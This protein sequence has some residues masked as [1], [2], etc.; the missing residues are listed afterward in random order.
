M[1]DP[2]LRRVT[3]TMHKEHD[4]EGTWLRNSIELDDVAIL[5][6]T[7]VTFVLKT[8][9]FDEVTHRACVNVLSHQVKRPDD[10]TN[11]T[12]E[13]LLSCICHRMSDI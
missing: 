9:F 8:C 13:G 3:N 11:N 10:S 4:I 5:C 7:L 6:F 1:D 12:F 2:G